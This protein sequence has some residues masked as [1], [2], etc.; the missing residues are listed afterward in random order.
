MSDMST[1]C[2]GCT[3]LKQENEQLKARI[4]SLIFDAGRKSV[5]EEVTQ[6]YKSQK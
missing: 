3:A 4:E 1:I 5:L 2:S 6:L